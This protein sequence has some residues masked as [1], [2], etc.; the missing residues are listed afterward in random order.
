LRR[1]ASTIK[2]YVN[3][4]MM[5]KSTHTTL[6]PYTCDVRLNTKTIAAAG[7]SPCRKK[8]RATHSTICLRRQEEQLPFSAD[9]ASDGVEPA[10]YR[11]EYWAGGE[12]ALH[13]DALREIKLHFMPKTAW[14]GSDILYLCPEP[15]LVKCSF[16]YIYGSK[17]W[18]HR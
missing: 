6:N 7:D 10:L 16:V 14:F 11:G 5:R 3:V 1:R 2:R 8:R 17:R 15:V 18:S 9:L 13:S 4:K 12:P